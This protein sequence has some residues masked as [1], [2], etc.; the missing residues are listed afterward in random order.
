MVREHASQPKKGCQTTEYRGP[1]I[2]RLTCDFIFCARYINTIGGKLVAAE[3]FLSSSVTTL[4]PPEKGRQSQHYKNSAASKEDTYPHAV[5]ASW[6]ER[7]EYFHDVFLI[8][9]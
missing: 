1:V 7:L 3:F 4:A 6:W 9:P 8:R 5:R 2:C